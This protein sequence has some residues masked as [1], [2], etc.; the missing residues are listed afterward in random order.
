MASQ[1]VSALAETQTSLEGFVVATKE[2]LKEAVREVLREEG[3]LGLAKKR[4]SWDREYW[5]DENWLECRARVL[6]LIRRN[7]IVAWGDLDQDPYFHRPK[8]DGGAGWTQPIQLHRAIDQR[9]LPNRPEAQDGLQLRAFQTGKRMSR[10]LTLDRWLHC[11]IAKA[12]KVEGKRGPALLRRLR[13]TF[14]ATE[15]CELDRLRVHGPESVEEDLQLPVSVSDS[16]EE[17]P[18]GDTLDEEETAI[19]EAAGGEPS[20]EGGGS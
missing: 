20:N 19:L 1:G 10:Y 4:A 7:L 5:G 11:A 2:D 13:E 17:T 14:H 3:I 16:G 15:P 8:E 18:A 9:F 6:R 12:L